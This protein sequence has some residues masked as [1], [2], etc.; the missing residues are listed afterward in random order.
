MRYWKRLN[1]DKT[2]NTVE[3]YS[4][5]LGVDGAI[6]ITKQES[7]DFM[8]SLPKLIE[9]PPRDLEAELTNLEERVKLLERR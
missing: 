9:E 5:D 1:T 7:E 3:S 2:I 8:A 4:H 6:E